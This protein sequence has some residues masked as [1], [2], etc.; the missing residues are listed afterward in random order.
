MIF[1]HFRLHRFSLAPKAKFACRCV[2]AHLSEPQHVV[3][4]VIDVD[5]VSSVHVI[6]DIVAATHGLPQMP[7]AG[8]L[9]KY[10]WQAILYSEPYVVQQVGNAIARVYLEILHKKKRC[11][12]YSPWP[13]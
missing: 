6:G 7:G 4:V 13:V 5:D 1:I 12:A 8:V 10:I 11:I 2:G 9:C 3:A